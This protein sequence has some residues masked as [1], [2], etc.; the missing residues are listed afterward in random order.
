MAPPKSPWNK[1]VQQKNEDKKQNGQHSPVAVPK[2][3]PMSP[4]KEKPQNVPETPSKA[5]R[6]YAQD[7]EDE[8]T[9]LQSIYGDDFETVTLK[10]AWRQSERAFRLTIKDNLDAGTM[11]VLSVRFTAT[12]PRS[13]PILDVERSSRLREKGQAALDEILD[14]MPKD[15]AAKGE[16]M[17]YDLAE[18]IREILDEDV[19]IRQQDG[20]SLED[21]RA[22]QEASAAVAAQKA[23]EE[24]LRK[25]K[26]QE[27]EEDRMMKQMLAEELERRKDSKRPSMPRHSS[28]HI[29]LLDSI[30]G[31]QYFISKTGPVT[32]VRVVRSSVTVG[33]DSPILA[34]KTVTVSSESESTKTSALALEAE[35]EQLKHV[36][37]DSIIQVMD[38]QVHQML[39]GS[40]RISVLAEYANKG[41]LADMMELV[42]SIPVDTARQWT[43]DL[44]E[45]LDFLHRNGVVHKLVHPSNVMFHSDNTTRLKLTDAGFQGAIH[46]LIR[47]A[48]QSAKGTRREKETMSPWE[49]PELLNRKT[50]TRTRKSDVWDLGVV[51]LQML[52]GLTTPDTFASPTNLLET[53]RLT[54]PLQDMIRKFFKWDSKKRPSAFDL[55]PCEFLRT[56]CAVYATYADPSSSGQL[57]RLSSAISLPRHSERRLRRFSSE[58]Q[59]L[60]R[61]AGD[62]TELGV[63]G[64]GGYGEVVKARNKID[65]RVYA[66][67]KVKQNSAAALSEVLSEVMLLCRLSHPYVV[68]YYQ[69]WKEDDFSPDLSETD[70]TLS[71]MRESSASIDVLN[72]NVGHSTGGLD[73]ISSSG[74]PKI[75]FG[76]DTDDDGESNP[77]ESGSEDLSSPK[78]VDKR[79]Q[80]Q[81]S[82][83]SNAYRPIK[84]TLYIQMDYCEK[85]TLRDLIRRD[86]FSH[87]DIVW[88]LLRQVLEGL[89]HIHG[90]R[91]IHRDLKPDNIFIDEAENPRIGDFGL[92]TS[93]QFS[94][95]DR[96]VG[97][98]HATD[99]DMTKSIGTTLYV[100][101]EIRSG[102]TGNY[103]EKVDMYSLGIILFEMCYPLKTAMERDRTIRLLR[104]KEHSLP[105]V[106]QGSDKALQG[107][108]ILSL[109][110]HKPSERPSSTELLRS[111]KLPFKV[112]D[113]AVKQALEG[114]SDPSSPYYQKILS[115][116][117]S[118][119]AAKEVKD[120]AWDMGVAN[121][122][123]ELTISDLV[124]QGFVRDQL[125]DVF[126]RHGAVEAPR[127]LV[128]PRSPLYVNNNIVQALDAYG[129]LFQ[130]PY[131]LTLPFARII[132]RQ[133][134]AADRSFA[135]GQVFRDTYTG[136]AP[137][138]SGEADFDVVS[139]TISDLALEEAEVLKV[140]DEVIDE[141]PP[142]SATHMCFHLNHS[143]LLDLILDFCRIPTSQRQDVKEV[144]SKL[145]IHNFTWQKIRN[146]LRLPTIGVSSTSLDDLARFDWRDSPDKAVP[147]LKTL[148]EGADYINRS[149]ATFEH[150]RRVIEHTKAFGVKR[151]IYISPLSSL[152]E[153]FYRGGILF[154]CLFD[155]KCRDVLAAGGRYDS[156][157]EEHRPRIKGQFSG[158]RAVGMNLGWDRLVSSMARF[159]RKE[160]KSG[161]AFLKKPAEEESKA[162]TVRR[163]DVL[164]ASFDPSTLRTA[165]VKLL[166]TLWSLGLS[167]ELAIDTRT[168]EELLA[169]YRDDRHSWIIIIKHDAAGT[170]KADL[171]VKSMDKAENKDTDVF[172]R[173]LI[174]YL[175]AE[176]RDRD[177]REST[178]TR[179]LLRSSESSSKDDDRDRGPVQ[180]LA[181]QH[182]SKKSNRGHIVDAAHASLHSL[183]SSY[184]GAPI[185]AIE[186]RDE[187][188]NW[189]R[190]TRL[191]EPESWRKVIQGV[192]LNER[193]YLQEVHSMLER[194]AM[195]WKGK[196]ERVEAGSD[197]GACRTAGVYNFRTGSCIL[198]DLGL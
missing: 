182:R 102:A 8:I 21:E 91:I 160:G 53:L 96:F 187:V 164:V 38:F 198:Y 41:S 185:A 175:R 162:V 116:L 19:R 59:P 70:D 168:P 104:E 130:L 146:E 69:A 190:E 31:D 61:Y 186:T 127:P 44:L 144:L 109:I 131:D 111:N 50:S 65:N 4:A 42:K 173:D 37:D 9:V 172:T 135:F 67:K 86:Y 66:I 122:A 52:F 195:E 137:R 110:S 194:Y 68:R 72:H 158:C 108:I 114:I 1:V 100:A 183:L 94:M 120:Y 113:E 2:Q 196:V 56:D 107:T 45:A 17:I 57:T 193:V 149:Q 134:P 171:R 129:T 77:F 136:G 27:A 159:M 115:A 28:S 128:F 75:E 178:R 141:F 189:I 13:T 89:E 12:Y 90:N 143:S 126:R 20:G 5:V 148:F 156:L 176:L 32:Q 3:P 40:W 33:L 39:N 48:S 29:G 54:E 153:K 132:A 147:R 35:L 6:D 55:M 145:N 106:F 167:A 7:Q 150:L 103:N 177:D 112:E 154:Q 192:P 63:L 98:G 124:L 121:G 179:L 155:T 105:A 125:T 83:S 73:F 18:K 23:E 62:W 22:V 24:R 142:L 117:F 10:G 74:F 161:S 123:H 71:S 46:D 99:G 60:S 140:L 152:N 81:R 14:V 25:E 85:K 181:S 47:D 36:H 64:R 188:L 180:V 88:R 95:S 16:V 157:I 133:A 93:G 30:D 49:P 43:L 184:S 139:H 26:V 82:H 80:L 76:D 101:P 15:F 169:T 92:A 163:C 119:K 118:N 87:P 166:A 191:S 97:S 78:A 79:L 51:F 170:G 174:P 11:V 151:K 197:S 58:Q 138:T 84:C 34:L 165:G